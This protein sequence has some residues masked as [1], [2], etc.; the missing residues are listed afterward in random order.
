MTANVHSITP[1]D[2]KGVVRCY[3]HGLE[4]AIRT[5]HTPQNPGRQFYC[6]PKDRGDADHC[7]FFA[8]VDDPIF[9]HGQ[10]PSTTSESPQT[11]LS[12][13]QATPATPTTPRKRTI[14]PTSLPTPGLSPSQKR[15]K[16][17]EEAL[18]EHPTSSR[19]SDGR[20][21]TAA[22]PLTPPISQE[23]K[24]LHFG[25]AASPLGRGSLT[26]H[27]EV[28]DPFVEQS[29]S[30]VQ[31]GVATSCSC[32]PPGTPTE[33]SADA[34]STLVATLNGL[35]DYVRRM[36][37]KRTAAEKGNEAKVK[38]IAELEAEVEK[39]KSKNDVLQDTIRVLIAKRD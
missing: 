13:T 33:L 34:I 20:D 5:S 21:D 7:K 26:E 1:I 10:P 25:S 31:P 4:A 9:R 11:M 8:W 23:I 32:P 17:M 19:T 36:E 37:R 30:V 35:P 6:C 29:P 39:L 12:Q 16:I 24:P 18:A 22:L 2:D 14:H 15:I 3:V 27:R 38:R 28:D